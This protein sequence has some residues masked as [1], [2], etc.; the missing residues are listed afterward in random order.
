[1]DPLASVIAIHGYHGV[2]N[3][4]WRPWLK[5]EL[6]A[7]NVAV[8]MPTMP[9]PA[10]P[11]EVEWL[12]VIDTLVAAAEE[13]VILLG[14]SLGG[15]AAVRWL[16]TRATK[17]I[18]GLIMLGGVIDA[19]QYGFH[20]T[21]SSPSDW[22]RIRERARHRIG[23]YGHDD[24]AVPFSEGET[25]AKQADALLLDVRGYGHFDAGSG[26]TEVPE[27]LQTIDQLIQL[28]K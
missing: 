18:H 17:Q 26:V 25:F 14:H 28:A 6:M 16:E 19:S 22:T 10:H 12:D 11:I 9:T 23:I 20:D 3:D 5:Q 8:A 4:A 2:A 15:L 1:M 21:F 13:P 7:R 24:S 27:L